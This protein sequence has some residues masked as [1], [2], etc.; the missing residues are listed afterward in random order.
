MS[1]CLSWICY[2]FEVNTSDNES[3]PPHRV[4]KF[5]QQFPIPYL[6]YS[7]YNYFLFSLTAGIY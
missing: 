7:P 4:P 6:F 2:L 1:G 3:T 5:V